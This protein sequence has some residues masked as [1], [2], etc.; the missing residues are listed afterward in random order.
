M[1]DCTELVQS[2]RD[3]LEMHVVLVYIDLIAFQVI[4]TRNYRLVIQNVLQTNAGLYK[5]LTPN[6]I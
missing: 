4:I 2:L 3:L 5:S 6:A 1:S